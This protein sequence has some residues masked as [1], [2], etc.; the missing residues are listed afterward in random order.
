MGFAVTLP[1][2]NVAVS[3]EI[4]NVESMVAVRIFLLLLGL[5]LG[6]FRSAPA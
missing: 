1:M 2:S 6:M 4:S 5:L 3:A